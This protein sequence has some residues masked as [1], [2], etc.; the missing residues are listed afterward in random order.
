MADGSA[1]KP[2]L[3]DDLVRSSGSSP[4]R[5]I[6][7]SGKH[8]YTLK[9]YAESREGVTDKVAIVRIEEL[10]PFPFQTLAEVLRPYVGAK[11]FIWAQEE[12]YQQGAWTHV[13]ERID[14]VL[15]RL[16][17]EARV[18]YSGRAPCPTVATAVGDWHKAEVTQITQ[19][20]FL[21]L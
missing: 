12:P 3:N 15:S 19:E 2:V 20:P 21:G 11:D 8:Y 5:V 1:F 7:C 13:R 17:V 4:V 10:A 18:R 16:N 14:D 9:Q 6:L